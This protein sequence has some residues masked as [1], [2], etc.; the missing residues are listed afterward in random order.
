MLGASGELC[1]AWKEVALLHYCRYGPTAG[2]V[3][4]RIKLGLNPRSAVWSL[5]K[6]ARLSILI[7]EIQIIILKN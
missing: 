4:C 6:Q 5:G 2:S 1:Y 3:S 7:N